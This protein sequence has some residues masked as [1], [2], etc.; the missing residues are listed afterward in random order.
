MADDID[1]E[2]K[3]I[4]ERAVF[5]IDS[6]LAQ[7]E[8]CG[9]TRPWV[10]LNR[11]EPLKLIHPRVQGAL[12]VI[13]EE[14]N[15]EIIE[16]EMQV[17]YHC[18]SSAAWGVFLGDT[19]DEYKAAK[20]KGIV[21]PAGYVH[22]RATRDEFIVATRATL[23]N[24]VKYRYPDRAALGHKVNYRAIES[25]LREYGQYYVQRLK[26]TGKIREF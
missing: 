6:T 7:C 9:S 12:P 1:R 20:A 15:G 13:K 3:E 18:L 26:L 23:D 14:K 17:C 22:R 5:V 19:D 2:V 16:R 8:I 21:S 4:V 24:A 11:N 25:D 10:S